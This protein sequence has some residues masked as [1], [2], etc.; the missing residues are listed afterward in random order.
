MS[1]AARRTRELRERYASDWRQRSRR[2]RI[3][4]ALATPAAA[5]PQH[6]L[7]PVPCLPSMGS[8]GGG[9]EASKMLACLGGEFFQQL[10]CRQFA[11]ER[12][13]LPGP[14]RREIRGLLRLR[15]GAQRR[16]R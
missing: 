11:A 14:Q 8:T 15:L 1:V 9:A 13:G 6:V 7:A 2:G 5:A 3:R 10:A 12:R 16:D 4:C